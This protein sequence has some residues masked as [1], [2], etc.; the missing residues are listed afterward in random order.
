MVEAERPPGSRLRFDRRRPAPAGRRRVPLLLAA[1]ALGVAAA[2]CLPLV[3]LAVRAG[4][5]GLTHFLDTL[6]E[7]R[8]R[9]L[10]ARSAGL[11]VAVTAATVVLAVPLGWLTARTDVP[12]RRTFSALTALPLAVPSYVGGYTFVA[13]LGPRGLLQGWLE[14]LGV[15]RLPSIYGFWGAFFVLT[16]S[17]YPYVLLTVRAALAGL[18]PALEEAGRSLGRSPRGTFFAVVLPQLRPAMASGALLVALYSLHDFGAVSLLRYDSFTRAIYQQYQSSFD[19]SRA[20]TLGLVL[21]ALTVVILAGEARS[22]GRLGV[23][24]ARRARAPVVVLG[25]WRWP[26]AAGCAVAVLFALGLPLGVIGYWM[27]RGGARVES[28][29]LTAELAGHSL[30]VAGLG[31]AVALVAAWPVAVLSARHPGRLASI[32]ERGSFLGYSLPGLV[33]ALS[34][35]FLGA[36]LVPAL[37]QTKTMLALAYVIL[38]LPQAVGALRASLLQVSPSLEEAARSLGCGRAGV[39]RRVTLPLVRPGVVAGFGLVFLTAMK[40]LPAT[41]LLAPIEFATLATQVWAST[42]EALFARAAAP[43]LAIVALSALPLVL[44]G[45][46]GEGRRDPAALPPE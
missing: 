19:R 13:A 5:G 24:R 21:V 42:N 10:L 11:T 46:L 29:S 2:A 26:A 22:R 44:T 40:E 32:A 25:R 16:L 9:D 41:L 39:W 30:Q 1:V 15:D 12:G 18:D 27:L 6:A 28:L 31:A 45:R 7:R 3:Y 43:A 8:T 36:R 14:P 38:F 23:A 17:T 20:A 37:Y 4:D 34:M 33:V 35:V